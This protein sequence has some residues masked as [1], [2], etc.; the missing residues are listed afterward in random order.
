[1]SP[2]FFN[3]RKPPRPKTITTEV[4]V[5][6]QET[7]GVSPTWEATGKR[8]KSQLKQ[9]SARHRELHQLRQLHC[10]F[11]SLAVCL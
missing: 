8:F 6:A 4:T 10:G 3:R 5:D 7:R 2:M 11:P 9:R 1:M